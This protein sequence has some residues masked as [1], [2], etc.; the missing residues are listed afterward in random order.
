MKL[1]EKVKKETDERYPIFLT[2]IAS[3]S[4]LYLFS[5]M[6]YQ[7]FISNRKTPA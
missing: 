3:V 6:F 5:F 7:K 2:L 4:F 1:I